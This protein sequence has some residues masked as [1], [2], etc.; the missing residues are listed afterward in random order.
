MNDE[1][2]E[3]NR[4]ERE[5]SMRKEA[6]RATVAQQ[7]P[8]KWMEMVVANLVREGVN[9]HKAR[10]LAE[11]FY[12]LRLEQPAP[13]QGWKMVPVEPTQKML[14]A[15]PNAYPADALVTWEAML[16]AAPQPAV[17]QEPASNGWKL[18]PIEPTNEM[19]RAFFE[20]A[21][22][23]VNE[24]GADEDVYIA[25][26][27]AA[28]NSHECTR[29]HPH[30]NMDAMCELRTEIARLANENARLKAKPVPVQQEP[31]TK[32]V[33]IDNM[34]KPFTVKAYVDPQPAQ[35]TWAGLTD[36]EQ[37]EIMS[38]AREFVSRGLLDLVEAKL[39]EKNNG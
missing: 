11:H 23:W 29:S 37:T 28:P 21:G 5:A 35:R 20:A 38:E 4:I 30:E 13:V 3:F 26:L 22:K 6:V 15:P 9:K 36:E 18:V 2:E 8:I 25:M 7:E 34:G 33:V 39:K 31:A 32:D 16:A 14:D 17:Q 12:S 24:E 19:M 1:D 27:E 10:E